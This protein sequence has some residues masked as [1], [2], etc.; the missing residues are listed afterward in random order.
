MGIEIAITVAQEE[1]RVAVLDG[2]TVTDLFG[3]RAK[4]K[5]FVGNIYKGRVAKVLPGMQAAFVD[6]GL[7]KAAFMHVSDLSMDAEPG[8]LL[9]DAE[10]DEKDS[11]LLRPKR[12]SAKPIEQLLSEGQELMVQISKGPIGTK[13][14]RVTTYVSLPGRY[15][16]FMPNV[17]QIGV[18]RRIPRDEERARLKEIMR[19]VRRPGCGYIVRTVSEG[20]REDDLKSDV[21]FLHVL[22]QDILAKREQLGA[23]ALLHT[24]LSLSFRVVRDLFGRKVDRL[25]IDS[26]SEYEALRDFVQRFSPEQTSRI[27]FYDKD[28]PLFD[29]LGVEQEISRAMSRKVWLKSGGYLVIDHTE[30]MTVI[31]VNTG[32]FVG[33]R[34]QEETILR[35][36]L[37]AAREVAYQLKLRGIGGIIIVDFIDMEREK[38]REKVYQALVDAMAADKARTR[39]SRI[40]DL[41][42]IEISRERVRE[43]LLRSLSEPCRYCEGRGY[44]KSPTTVA[45]EIF[46]DIRRIGPSSDRQM[47]VLGTHP[48][49]AELLLDEERHS[50]EML[51]RDHSAKIVVTPDEQLHLEQYDLVVM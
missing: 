50:V 2:G 43:D 27:H 24:D 22:W 13:G 46:R 36:N 40:S 49:V 7:E 47:I 1:T 20:V 44:T 21:D 39:I 48:T 6:I 37:E 9:V 34:D 31:D 26:R 29:H 35:N 11:D 45:Y 51:E 38:N 42:L 12:Q 5:D 4:H 30:A 19:R 25:W 28:E 18:S 33:K 17:E 23:P 14:S 32:R 16:V 41:G 3:D 15:L 8:D 10:E